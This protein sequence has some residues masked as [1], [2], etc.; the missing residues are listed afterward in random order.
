MAGDRLP[1]DPVPCGETRVERVDVA[2]TEPGRNP[3]EGRPRGLRLS[4]TL[5]RER[6]PAHDSTAAGHIGVPDSPPSTRGA[7]PPPP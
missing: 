1:D 5:A 3:L 4:S 2:E 6:A 7:P